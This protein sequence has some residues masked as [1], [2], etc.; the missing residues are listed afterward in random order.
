[1]TLLVDIQNPE[2]FTSL[3]ALDD[4][5]YWAAAAWLDESDAGVVLR[6]VAEAESQ[7][8]NYSF[9]NKDYPTNVLSFVYEPP[10]FDFI[11]DF[12]VGEVDYL[13]DLI[14]C[15][16]VVEREASEQGKPLVHHWAHMVVHGLLHLQ[17]YDHITE[18]EAHIM[19]AREID[20]LQQLGFPN[21]Y[22]PH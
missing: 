5:T 19:E 21:P 9:R 13:G 18:L 22:E 10:P 16:P 2:N 14:I 4:L 12:E 1:V 7:T 6:I 3:P 15:L 11:D 20:I 8:L 17:G